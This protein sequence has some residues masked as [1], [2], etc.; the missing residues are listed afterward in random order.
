MSSGGKREGAGR[1]KL[2]VD[3]KKV[4]LTIKVKPDVAT[5]LR[6][7]ARDRNI[8]IGDY[9]TTLLKDGE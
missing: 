1:K 4:N 5:R 3:L 9:V 6:T 2:P 7:G 8:S